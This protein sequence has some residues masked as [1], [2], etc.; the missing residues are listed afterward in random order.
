[1]AGYCT[2][3]IMRTVACIA[4][5]DSY[6]YFTAEIRQKLSYLL[7]PLNHSLEIYYQQCILAW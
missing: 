3:F 4:K 2:G 1:M 6:V 5:N 7:L